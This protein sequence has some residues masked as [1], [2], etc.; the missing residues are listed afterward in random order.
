MNQNAMKNFVSDSPLIGVS[1]IGGRNFSNDLVTGA[2]SQCL[3]LVNAQQE[4][5]FRLRLA[6]VEDLNTIESMVKG[7]AEYVNEPDA[8]EI[9]SSD[10]RKDGFDLEDPLWYCLLVDRVHENGS[11]ETCGYA[12][13]FVGYLLGSGRFVYLEDLFLQVEHRGAGGGKKT[14]K[15]LA[16]LCL[17][18]ECNSLYWQALD[19]NTT[20]LKFYESIGATIHHG[21]RTSRYAGEALKRFAQHDSI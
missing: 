1:P 17:S 15:T 2:F 18:L 3:D 4:S 14:M 5:G 16:A 6:Q 8:I 13:V 7:L 10:Y 19:W 9:G 12:F 11:V 20:G 21:E